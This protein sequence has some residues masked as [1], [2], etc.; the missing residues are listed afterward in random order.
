MVYEIDEDYY[1]LKIHGYIFS[2]GSS[3]SEDSGKSD[4]DKEYYALKPPPINID[5]IKKNRIANEIEL[6]TPHTSTSE[7]RVVERHNEQSRSL[8]RKSPSK[9]G[10]AV[11]KVSNLCLKEVPIHRFN[12]TKLKT[13]E[14]SDEVKIETPARCF[15]NKTP[16]SFNSAI[17]N[18]ELTFANRTKT[19][20]S[21]KDFETNTHSRRNTNLMSNATTNKNNSFNGSASS[22][23][24]NRPSAT[25]SNRRNNMDFSSTLKTSKST[26]ISSSTPSRVTITSSTSPINSSV[27]GNLPPNESSSCKNVLECIISICCCCCL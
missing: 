14:T 13:P 22:N 7:P 10:E 21:N 12:S 16:S 9:N 24:E 18:Q 23:K 8:N 15:L 3:G 4:F 20:S 1:A 19:S 11:D 6:S 5:K 2:S 25:I 26:D 27:S 17:K